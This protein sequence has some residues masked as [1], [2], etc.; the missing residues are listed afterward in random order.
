MALAALA[1]SLSANSQL[2]RKSL[3]TLGVP[4]AAAPPGCPYLGGAAGGRRWCRKVVSGGEWEGAARL[5]IAGTTGGADLYQR[6][7]GARSVGG[8]SYA[9]S[10]P[11]Q[12]RQ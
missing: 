11:V 1:C 5:S 3:L 8:S 10:R 12:S 7:H 6:D 4:C 2:A 9:V